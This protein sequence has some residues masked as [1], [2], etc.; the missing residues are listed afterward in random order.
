MVEKVVS[1][2]FWPPSA[3]ENP[4]ISTSTSIFWPKKI[5]DD[6][7]GPPSEGGGGGGSPTLPGSKN[8]APGFPVVAA[9]PLHSATFYLWFFRRAGRAGFAIVTLATLATLGFR[10]NLD[11]P[12][13]GGF[14]GFGPGFGL[15]AEGRPHSNYRG[16]S[17]AA[18]RRIQ[19]IGGFA[20]RRPANPGKSPGF[21]QG[22]A[23][24]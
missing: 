15:P 24:N 22:L 11:P 23:E 18:G 1:K 20:G 6:T 16:F 17:P 14:P 7:F 10:R 2:I 21:G 8:C 19:I 4:I 3:A 12:G 5:A 9:L 13:E